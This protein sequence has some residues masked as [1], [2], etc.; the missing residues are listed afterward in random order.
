MSHMQSQKS[1]PRRSYQF[2][3]LR[4][5]IIQNPFWILA[6]KQLSCLKANTSTEP[7][8]RISLMVTATELL[9]HY[10]SSNM[11]GFGCGGG[12][13][14][15]AFPHSKGSQ[16]LGKSP[17]D[18]PCSWLL[19]HVLGVL[20]LSGP[21]GRTRAAV[22]STLP[23]NLRTKMGHTRPICAAFAQGLGTH[24]SGSPYQYRILTW[25]RFWLQFGE[26]LEKT[27]LR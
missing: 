6:M 21:A 13:H 10:S 17:W 23:G 27:S 25:S 22:I 3:V 12:L 26:G 24:D 9:Q 16:S 19:L 14:T 4:R 7:H 18:N 5:T 1:C 11:W 20:T 15:T 2:C 8:I